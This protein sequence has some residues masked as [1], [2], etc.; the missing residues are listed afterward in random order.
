MPT[1]TVSSG[2]YT[3]SVSESSG[4]ASIS[5]Q[6]SIYTV[7]DN[8]VSVNSQ[9]TLTATKTNGH[10][11][12]SVPIPPTYEG[13]SFV[14]LSQA[15]GSGSFVPINPALLSCAIRVESE[16]LVG[17]VVGIVFR[18]APTNTSLMVQYSF[19]YQITATT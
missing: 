11:L 2:T 14:G 13:A 15:I 16:D 1:L 5:H 12:V 10:M 6:N 18:G 9:W 7:V 17:P 4:L 19:S 8:V 3:P